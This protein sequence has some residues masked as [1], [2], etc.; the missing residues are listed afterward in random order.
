MLKR[1]EV[2]GFRGF[3]R[4]IILDMMAGSYEFNPS[5]IKGDFIKNALIYGKNGVG[6]SAFG[7]AL[8]DIVH[9]L[10]DCRKMNASY[11]TPYLNLESRTDRAEFKYTFE[12]NGHELEYTYHKRSIDDLLDEKLMMDG[13]RIVEYSYE[14]RTG[15]YFNEHYLANLQINLPDNKLSVIKYIKNNTPTG[16]IQPVHDLVRF[17]E[18]MLWYRSLTNGNDFVGFNS[19]TEAID[20]FIFSNG[21]VQDLEE[22]FRQCDINYNLSILESNGKHFLQVRFGES[23]PVSFWDVASTGTKAL[24][25]F[26]YW[27]KAAFGKITFLFIDEFDAFLHFEASAMVLKAINEIGDFQSIVTTHNTSLMDNDLTRPDCCFILSGKGELLPVCRATSRIL[28]EGHNIAKMYVNGR[29]E[30]L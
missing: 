27:K 11:L 21:L 24:C 25:L 18:G 15:N 5:V 19:Q 17:V 23:D 29:F 13:E 9:H 7:I 26:Y 14:T 2:S 4:R 20:E 22:F 16:S 1:F 3:K 28:R 12:I 30:N 6:K 10:T 8:F